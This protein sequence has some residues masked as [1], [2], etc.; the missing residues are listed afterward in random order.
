MN[1][2]VSCHPARNILRFYGTNQ[3]QTFYWGLM[4]LGNRYL[5]N[6]PNFRSLSNK[7]AHLKASVGCF[8][9]CAL[10]F[11]LKFWSPW[12]VVSSWYLSSV[13][14]S[15]ANGSTIWGMMVLHVATWVLMQPPTVHFRE[16]H[17]RSFLR[18]NQ[19]LVFWWTR[20]RIL[21][22]QIPSKMPY[23]KMLLTMWCSGGLL[24]KLNEPLW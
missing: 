9:L 18:K 22:G 12:N 5:T 6:G 23:G 7:V 15:N 24:A 13:H 10:P 4:T 2:Q 3:W 11:P 8:I 16:P 17:A 21:I 1:W 19:P 14:N 20:C